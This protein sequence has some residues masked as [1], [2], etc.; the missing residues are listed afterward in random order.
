MDMS[1]LVLYPYQICM[2]HDSHNNCLIRVEHGCRV[3][4]LWSMQNVHIWHAMQNFW[5]WLAT[6]LRS[7][8][9]ASR[10]GLPYYFIF[11]NISYKIFRYSLFLWSM[12]CQIHLYI[13]VRHVSYRSI[14]D[15]CLI[16]FGY[17]FG[18]SNSWSVQNV[19]VHS[20]TTQSICFWLVIN[21]KCVAA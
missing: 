1:D 13:C 14:H 15:M 5:V 18:V 20:Q 16:H 6:D 3:S 8:R 19:H 9:N 17:G 7:I 10:H 11:Y 12:T 4:N 21:S 2:R